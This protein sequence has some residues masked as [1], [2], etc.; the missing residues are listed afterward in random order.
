MPARKSWAARSITPEPQI[1]MGGSSAMVW[2]SNLRLAG[3]I[4][5]RSMTPGPA[6]MPIRVTPPSS[7]G[8]AA[9][10]QPMSQS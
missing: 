9:P 7:A 3:S 10:A 2:I 4:V 8:P 6:S 5:T 1:P